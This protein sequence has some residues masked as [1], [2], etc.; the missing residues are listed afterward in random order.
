[1]VA[2]RLP[3]DVMTGSL[4]WVEHGRLGEQGLG[5]GKGATG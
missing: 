1:M 5:G 2:K 3:L 4:W